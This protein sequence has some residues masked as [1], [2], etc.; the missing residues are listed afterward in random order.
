[1]CRSCNI[2]NNSQG[3]I[4]RESESRG[5]SSRERRPQLKHFHRYDELYCKFKYSQT[6]GRKHL[7]SIKPKEQSACPLEGRGGIE[8]IRYQPTSSY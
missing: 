5:Q 2:M 1:M 6:L 4:S 3:N 7:L 8:I